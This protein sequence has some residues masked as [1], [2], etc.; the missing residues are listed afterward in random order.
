GCCGCWVSPR[1]GGRARLCCSALASC[2]AGGNAHVHQ[3]HAGLLGEEEDPVVTDDH[4]RPG[5]TVDQGG[6]VLDGQTLP[7]RCEEEHVVVSMHRG[8][9]R[10]ADCPLQIEEDLEVECAEIL[11]VDRI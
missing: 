8:L 11:P 10:R 1:W 6:D 3:R 9:Y 7:V 2:W 4:S 5:V